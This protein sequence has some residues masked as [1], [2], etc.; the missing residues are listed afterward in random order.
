MIEIECLL[1]VP[2]NTAVSCDTYF[3]SLVGF[4]DGEIELR[5]LEACPIV[6]PLLTEPDVT[7]LLTSF[8]T[9]AGG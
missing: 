2:V 5:F 4:Y 6:E 7:R 3:N 1:L 8:L 9:R